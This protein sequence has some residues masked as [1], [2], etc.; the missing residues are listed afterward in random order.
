[1][2]GF[3]ANLGNYGIDEARLWAVWHGLE[4]AWDLNISKLEVRLDSEQ[5]ACGLLSDMVLNSQVQNL[6][7]ATKELV[8][9]N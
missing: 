5:V 8:S 1:M 7:M 2:R 3:T 4:V 9:R 6:L